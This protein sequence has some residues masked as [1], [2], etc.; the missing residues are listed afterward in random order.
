MG[1]CAGC[2]E[3]GNEHGPLEQTAGPHCAVVRSTLSTM[4]WAAKRPACKGK[5]HKTSDARAFERV[6]ARTA[7]SQATQ[8]PLSPSEGHR[9]QAG[10]CLEAWCQ[11]CR[12]RDGALD[13]AGRRATPGAAH[14]A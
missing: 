14:L 13:P 9:A 6:Q 7:P 12:Y 8:A 3:H 5:G 4:A 2:S 10:G 11:L 1:S